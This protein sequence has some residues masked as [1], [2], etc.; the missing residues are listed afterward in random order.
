MKNNK[1]NEMTLAELRELPFLTIKNASRVTGL[2]VG[3]LRKL[4]AEGKIPTT[5]SGRV[6]YVA[7]DGLKDAIAS[8]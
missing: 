3:M 1:A 4:A 2:P 8:L 7:M 5:N 6:V